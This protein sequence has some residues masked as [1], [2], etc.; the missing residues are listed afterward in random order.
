MTKT[1][2][3]QTEL[4]PGEIEELQTIKRIYDLHFGKLVEISHLL[5]TKIDEILAAQAPG[6]VPID[7]IESHARIK[8]E[9]KNCANAWHMTE[10]HKPENKLTIN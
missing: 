5:A 10:V 9:I 2:M 1:I 4:E 3:N 8:A 6:Q 7:F